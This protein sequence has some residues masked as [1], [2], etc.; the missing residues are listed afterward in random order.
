MRNKLR[1]LIDFPCDF[2]QVILPLH[3]F[4]LILKMKKQNYWLSDSPN[5]SLIVF[6][7]GLLFSYTTWNLKHT[8]REFSMAFLHILY[9][10]LSQTI[11]L[12]MFVVCITNSFVNRDSVTFWGRGQSYILNK[13]KI[14]SP[15]GAKLG[16]LLAAPFR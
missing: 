10:L 8:E 12:S 16:S 6:F 7:Y 5:C 1:V 3:I 2:G 13:I 11:L 15:F 9:Q 4:F 14:M